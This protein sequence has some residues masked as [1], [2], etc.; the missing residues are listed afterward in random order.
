M[1]A[2]GGSP[3]KNKRRKKSAPQAALCDVLKDIIT[4]STAM[5]KPP[6]IEGSGRDQPA[7]PH[8]GEG[9]PR[10]DRQ[11]RHGAGGQPEEQLLLGSRFD[12]FNQL[13]VDTIK[14]SVSLVAEPM[15]H[16]IGI[17]LAANCHNWSIQ[18]LERI[19]LRD[20]HQTCR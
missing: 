10:L 5:Q 18:L 8:P 14:I 3:P 2:V 17:F 12:V 20:G 7:A 11:H 1:A 19:E 16:H 6:G 4:Y 13:C 15:P 9:G